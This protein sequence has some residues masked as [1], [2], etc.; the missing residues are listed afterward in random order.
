MMGHAALARCGDQARFLAA[1]R[2]ACQRH[3][4]RADEADLP[5]RSEVRARQ[6]RP[7]RSTRHPRR[8]WT[9]EDGG[10]RAPAV[11]GDQSCAAG[12]PG[13]TCGN[14]VLTPEGVATVAT[15]ATVARRECLSVAEVARVAGGGGSETAFYSVV[16]NHRPVASVAPG[17]GSRSYRQK[18]YLTFIVLL[19]IL[20]LSPMP[21]NVQT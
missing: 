21:I 5:V 18:R 16:L 8:A 14:R 4:S 10:R 13:M 1:Q 17:H 2:G 7:A 11:R 20:R 19:D 6:P 9:G 12:W 3:R 15:L